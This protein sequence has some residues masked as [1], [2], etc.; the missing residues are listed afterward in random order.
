MLALPTSLAFLRHSVDHDADQQWDDLGGQGEGSSSVGGTGLANANG[1]SIGSLDNSKGATIGG[2]AGLGGPGLGGGGA[3]IGNE[4]EISELSN[5]GTMSGGM[6]PAGGFV[7]NV[8][9]Y[10]DLGTITTLTNSGAIVGGTATAAIFNY[11]GRIT[12]ATNSGAVTGGSGAPG[13]AGGAGLSNSFISHLI[14][15]QREGRRDLRR[16][17]GNRRG[18]RRRRRK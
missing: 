16:K 12:T 10:N 5:E 17:R 1:S 14:A 8:G 2:A 15:D 6:G 4:G 13:E 3:G 11:N 9:L 7:S 18:G